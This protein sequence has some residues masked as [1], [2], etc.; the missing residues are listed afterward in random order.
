MKKIIKIL[1]VLLC[2]V[3]GFSVVGCNN[4]NNGSNGSNGGSVT[5]KENI[6]TDGVHVYDYTQTNEYVVKNSVSDYKIVIANNADNLEILAKDELVLF[7]EEATGVSLPVITDDQVTYSDTEKVIS[8]GKNAFYTQALATANNLSTEGK[9]LEHDGYM[10]ETVGKSIFIFG[11]YVE[12]T[13]FGVYGYLNIEFNYDCYSNIAYHIDTQVENVT[14][15]DFSVID[16]PDYKFR[17]SYDSHVFNNSPTEWRMGFGKGENYAIGSNSAHTA[18]LYLPRTSAD[19]VN[20]SGGTNILGETAYKASHPDWYSLDGAQLC[21]LARGNETEYQAMLNEMFEIAKAYFMTDNGY[22]FRLGHSDGITWCNCTAC[23]QSKNKYGAD[24]ASVIL[25]ANALAEKLDAWMQT[26]EGKPYARDYRISVLSYGIT[27]LPPATYNESK[28]IWEPN[29]PEVVCNDRVIP[30][31][32]PLE[33]NYNYTIFDNVNKEF[34]NQMMGWMAIAK[35]MSFYA[36]CTNYKYYL[37][38]SAF[39]D[40]FQGFYQLG[41][42]SGGYYISNLGQRTQSGGA[43]AWHILKSYL[44]AKLSWNVNLDVGKLTEQFFENYFGEASEEMMNFYQ[45][46]RVHARYTIENVYSAG[47]SV[48][49]PL[50]DQRYWPKNMLDKWLGY[51]NDALDAIEHYKRVDEQ[52]YQNYYDRITMERVS[53]YYLMV[54]LYKDDYAEDFVLEMK[55]TF[56]EDCARLGIT[57]T[58]DG[59]SNT[60]DKILLGWGV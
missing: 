11:D 41:A 6:F 26:E 32:A 30:W 9:G 54:E 47:L 29:A 13:V 4:E 57:G 53:L 14:L 8:L 60:V 25:F 48:Y 33:I 27:L 10:I 52:L 18:F 22:F 51:V 1:S 2:L 59:A 31:Y 39:F 43:T 20:M 55:L 45:S 15:K 12:A 34:Y 44:I 19:V 56:K 5:M 37:T 40:H 3:I 24:S 23:T 16:V 35:E 42:K 21:Y 38:P 36:Y 7:F 58:A 49:M 28:G 46:Y 17:A 50:N